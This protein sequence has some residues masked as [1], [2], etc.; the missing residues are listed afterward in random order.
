MEIIKLETETA[1]QKA[2]QAFAKY[3]GHARAAITS[4]EAQCALRPKLIKEHDEMPSAVRPYFAHLVRQTVGDDIRYKS[5][6][7]G[8]AKPWLK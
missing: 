6:Q 2:N 7:E 3:A 5:R 8:D 4:L 1:R